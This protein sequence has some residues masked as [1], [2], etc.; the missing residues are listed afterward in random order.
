MKGRYREESYPQG[1]DEDVPPS[2]SRC[3]YLKVRVNTPDGPP[4]RCHAHRCHNDAKHRGGGLW[5]CDSCD[6]AHPFR[7]YPLGPEQPDL[8][9]S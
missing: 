1:M 6:E 2:V 9:F 5:L 4:V 7:K 3:E 8:E